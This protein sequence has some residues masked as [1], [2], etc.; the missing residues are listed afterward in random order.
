M[1][2]TVDVEKIGELVYEWLIEHYDV[3]ARRATTIS[4]KVEELLIENEDN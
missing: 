4:D 1:R 3:E 2:V